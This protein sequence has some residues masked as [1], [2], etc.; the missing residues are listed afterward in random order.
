MRIKV[1][2]LLFFLLCVGIF[3]VSA[4]NSPK[5][6]PFAPGET[7]TYEGKLS[8]AIF[9]GISVADLVFSVANSPD[10][11][12][13][14]LT[15]EATSKGG[16]TKLFNFRFRQTYESIVEKENFRVKRTV[17]H[18][19]QRDRVRDGEATFDYKERRVTYVE[20]NP[21]DMMR[22]PRRIASAIR[23]D[24][25]DLL[26]AIYNI[27]RLPLTVGKTF[28][29][30]VSDSGLVYTIPLRVTAREQQNSILG[31]VWCFRV[32]PQVFGAKRFIEEEGKMIIWIT[33]DKSRIPIRSQIQTGM[34]KLEIK[35]KRIIK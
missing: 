29:V 5:N 12:Y 34:G 4:Q 14:V 20:T 26:S 18:D 9:R 19:E 2:P 32:E 35:L 24:T 1:S 7:L 23:P 33:D 6:N 11:K 3:S 13:Y 16:L 10:P 21:K 8:K 27:R 25:L 28:D 30:S 17:K 31:K 22:P 15:T